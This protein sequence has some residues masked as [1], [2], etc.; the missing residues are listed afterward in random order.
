[1]RLARSLE[2]DVLD[3]FTNTPFSGNPLSIVYIPEDE[4]DITQAQKQSIAREFNF[5]ETVFLHHIRNGGSLQVPATGSSSKID[6]FDPSSEIPF[7]GHPTIGTGWILLESCPGLESISLQTK[8]GLVPVSRDR[9]ARKVRLRVPVDFKCHGA[10]HDADIKPSSQLI[11][12]D[13]I[14]GKEAPEPVA[15]IV[16][17]MSFMLLELAGEDALGRFVPSSRKFTVGREV[18][19][20]WEGFTG[21]YLYA[22]LPDGKIRARMFEGSIEDPATG[23]AVSTLAVYLAMEKGEGRWEFSITQGVEMGRRSEIEVTVEMGKDSTILS[24]ELVGEAVSVM[25]GKIYV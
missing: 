22:V 24:V 1:M 9:Q 12:E 11:S 3:V 7:A 23:S 20:E 4:E 21:L 5:S 8:A 10:Y 15:S 6:I 14:R 13:F 17:G 2:Y 16:K 18:L 19:G 25:S